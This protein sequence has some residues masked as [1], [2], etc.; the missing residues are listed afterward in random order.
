MSSA[1]TGNG[2]SDGYYVAIFRFTELWEM[3]NAGTRGELAV[4]VARARSPQAAMDVLALE[5]A[6]QGWGLPKGRLAVFPLESGSAPRST[7]GGS[8]GLLDTLLALAEQGRA[9]VRATADWPQECV[10]ALH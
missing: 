5:V 1:T 3:P 10:A 7:L 2:P 6:R 8:I 4:G 9:V